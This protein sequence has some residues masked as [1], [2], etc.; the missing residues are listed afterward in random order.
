MTKM[1]K[2]LWKVWMMKVK[3]NPESRVKRQ[4]DNRRGNVSKMEKS[5]QEAQYENSMIW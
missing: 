1:S 3:A 2:M 4:I 5:V